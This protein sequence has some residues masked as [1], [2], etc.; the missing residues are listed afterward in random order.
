MT[1]DPLSPEFAQ[2]PFEHLSAMRATGKP[3]VH[4]NTLKRLVSV[5]SYADCEAV[6]QDH[7]KWS[8]D[9]GESVRKAGLG[10]A[11]ILLFDDP[12]EHT[13]RRNAVK[14]QFMPAALAGMKAAIESRVAN[15][16]SKANGKVIDFVSEIAAPLTISTI[17][18]MLSIE[19]DEIAKVR[20]WTEKLARI[21]GVANFLHHPDDWM[22]Q[23]GSATLNEM[24][25]FFSAKI[26]SHRSQRNDLLSVL[27]ASELSRDEAVSMAKFI[28]HA[29]NETTTNLL[30]QLLLLLIEHPDQ[31]ARLKIAPELASGAIDEA[32]R[33][34]GSFRETERVAKLDC[35]L[36]GV[37][38]RKGDTVVTWLASGNR[39]HSV[40]VEPDRFDI[41]RQPNRHLSFARG[42]HTCLGNILAKSEA[43]AFVGALIQHHATLELVG[44]NAVRW[45][46]NPLMSGVTKLDVRITLK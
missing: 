4:T 46:D 27:L 43:A 3:Y 28:L 13:R 45:S 10:D 2:T 23:A 9:R 40:F 14:R 17:G 20:E 11:M 32:L 33:L 16:L 12:P 44:D 36:S 6:L 7:E 5:F 29:G 18:L 8:S 34:R 42:I 21:D 38:V 41:A 22:E 31:Y 26:K 24:A 35:E 37:K 1:F 19:E 39:D 15:L 30:S 25:D